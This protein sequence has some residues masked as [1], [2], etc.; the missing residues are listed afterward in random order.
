VVAERFSDDFRDW[1]ALGLGATGEPLLEVGVKTNGFDGRGSGA[2]SGSAALAAA[3]DDLGD[4]VAP[5]G[6]VGELVD[7]LVGDRGAGLRVGLLY[8]EIGT[9]AAGARA[10]PKRDLRP[11]A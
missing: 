6:F 5:L 7:E 8:Y 11:S 4:V 2:E 9:L 3:G 1:Y 10:I